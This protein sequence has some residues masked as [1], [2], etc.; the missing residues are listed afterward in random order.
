MNSC[1][2]VGFGGPVV[3]PI[4]AFTYLHSMARKL[5]RCAII[6]PVSLLSMIVSTGGMHAQP[7]PLESLPLLGPTFG[8]EFGVPLALSRVPGLVNRFGVPGTGAAQSHTGQ[9]GATLL[10][11]QLLSARLGLRL[12]T[13]LGVAQGR[14]E[15]DPFLVD[16]VDTATGVIQATANRFTLN[17][18]FG[19]IRAGAGLDARLAGPLYVGVGLW[20]DFRFALEVVEREE[21]LAPDSARFPTGVSDR[22]IAAGHEL[23]AEAFR[24]GLDG[25]VGIRVGLNSGLALEPSIRVTA[26]VG[27]IAD[28][29]GVRAWSIAA[30]VSLLMPFG[31]SGSRDNRLAQRI[32]GLQLDLYAIDGENVSQIGSLRPIQL[33]HRRVVPLLPVVFF[34]DGSPLIPDRYRLTDRATADSFSMADLSGLDPLA[35]MRRSIDVIAWRLGFA[36]DARLTLVS[37]G[38]G[39]GDEFAR[40]RAEGLRSYLTDV[41]GIAPGRI[42]IRMETLPAGRQPMVEFRCS[43]SSLVDDQ[44][45]VEWVERAYDAPII[46]MD[47]IIPSERGLRRWRVELSRLGNRIAMF[48]GQGFSDGKEL[49]GRILLDSIYGSGDEAPIVGDLFV[50]SMDGVSD[51][52]HDVLPLRTIVVDADSVNGLIVDGVLGV[53]DVDQ[54]NVLT[55]QSAG[56]REAVEGVSDGCEVLVWARGAADSNA[57]PRVAADVFAI[58]V[59]RGARPRSM[60]LTTPLRGTWTFDDTPESRLL[61]TGICFRISNPDSRA[62]Q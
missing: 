56:L 22:L 10:E 44:I 32:Q 7:G 31:I 25:R 9:V 14:F 59:K 40:Q 23:G 62:A 34:D 21:I 53:I 6:L 26:D 51:T 27:S 60:Q 1:R 17:T 8:Y 5:L 42:A 19:L 48:Q 13:H 35:M 18:T 38:R 30:E 49:T 28:G 47:R 41:W 4:A 33:L 61:T 36:T 24:Y 57:V 11:P 55:P 3:F 12:H 52:A 2:P 50:E 39:D 58:I 46:G 16:V 20:S 54:M 45:R 43:N 37:W 29:V 15:S